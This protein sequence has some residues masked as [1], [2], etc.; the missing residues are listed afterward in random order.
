LRVFNTLGQEVASLVNEPQAAGTY[1]VTFDARA[2]SSG[3]YVYQV[4]AGALTQTRQMLL[5][6]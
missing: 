4:R 3:M 2:L 5:L 1:R 6:K